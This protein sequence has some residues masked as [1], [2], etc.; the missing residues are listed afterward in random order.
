MLL[1]AV[2]REPTLVQLLDSQL[3]NTATLVWLLY[4]RDCTFFFLVTFLQVFPGRVPAARMNRGTLRWLSWRTG[5]LSVA[6]LTLAQIPGLLESVARR[7]R[8]RSNSFAA[9][10]SLRVVMLGSCRSLLP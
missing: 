6:S 3:R 10:R 2:V 7:Y 9:V 1:G 8:P 4:P 5:A